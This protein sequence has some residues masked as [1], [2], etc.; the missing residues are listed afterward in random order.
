MR[1][2]LPFRAV[3]EAVNMRMDS[4]RE[5]SAYLVWLASEGREGD[6]D[7]DVIIHFKY[8]W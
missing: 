3:Q 2:H 1:G 8:G 5:M 4:A 7:L 6:G